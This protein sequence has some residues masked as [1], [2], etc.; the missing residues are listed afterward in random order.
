LYVGHAAKLEDVYIYICMWAGLI[1][2]WWARSWPAREIAGRGCVA[3]R[4]VANVVS[5]RHMRNCQKMQRLYKSEGTRNK[6][7]KPKEKKNKKRKFEVPCLP[8]LSTISISPSI[9]PPRSSLP[10]LR[11]LSPSLGF[12]QLRAQPRSLAPALLDPAA[13]ISAISART[14]QR[15][16]PQL[17]ARTALATPP[18]VSGGAAH[19][20]STSGG[21]AGSPPSSRSE[22]HAPDGAVKGPALGAAPAA[23]AA[24]STPASD[25]TFLRLN[26]LDINGDDAPSSQ[27]PTRLVCANMCLMGI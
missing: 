12:V 6:R 3:R 1:C 2:F 9:L 10:P 21:T 22:Q 16:P 13:P 27:A 24:A 20:A 17:G 18:P 7:R 14:T 19:S 15:S 23:A 4:Q 26:N 11:L 5:S 25:S 8:A